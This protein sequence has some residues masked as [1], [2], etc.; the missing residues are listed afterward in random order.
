MSTDVRSAARP[1]LREVMVP[2]PGELLVV[3][4][5]P[6]SAVAV[7]CAVSGEVD[8]STAPH[9]RNHLLG[10]I[11][12]RGPDLVV[13]LGEVGFLGAAGLTVLV[14][15]RAAAAA[16][17]VGLYV[18]A[19]T[20]PVLR[21]LAVTG[22]DVEFE[23]FPRVGDVPSRRPAEASSARRG[24]APASGPVADVRLA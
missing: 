5:R 1:P 17:G 16:S 4:V 21:P 20:R 24:P 14:E 19:R 23:V 7:L 2:S 9:L 15:A 18:V 11:S 8:L 13:D 10:Q 3:A 6:L 22:L 12:S